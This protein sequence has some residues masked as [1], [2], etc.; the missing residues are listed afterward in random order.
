MPKA[1]GETQGSIVK[2]AG[3]TLEVFEYFR[4]YQQPATVGEIAAAL[5]LPQ[6]STS[7][8]LKSLVAL[9]YLDYKPTTRRFLPTY[10]VSLLGNWIQASRYESEAIT[11]IMEALRRETGETVM[12]GLQSGPHMQYV[13][14]L[15]AS[16]AVQLT[17]TAGTVRPMTL[18][19]A[20]Q[21]LLS[22]KTNTQVRAIVRRNNADA[23][24]AGQRVKESEFL[25]EIELVR[26]RGYAESRGRMAPGANVIAMLAPNDGDSPL[27]A[28]GIGGPMPRIDQRRKTIIEAMRE[29]LGQK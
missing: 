16:Y 21:I 15:A 13:H 2:S 26:E 24:S 10:R 3:R 17:V 18:S 20:G 9:N 8:L 6:S 7:M 1:N 28:I 11:E 19:A 22:Q 23:D 5:G 4:I 14:I 12:L 29:H 27:L 25:K